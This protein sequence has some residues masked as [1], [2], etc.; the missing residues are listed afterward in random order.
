M[1]QCFSDCATEKLYLLLVKL[2]LSITV[3]EIIHL[4]GTKN[5]TVIQ[6]LFKLLRYFSPDQYD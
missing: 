3:H 6:Y 1:L 2:K 4:L 5:F